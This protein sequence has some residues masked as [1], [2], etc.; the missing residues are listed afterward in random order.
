MHIDFLNVLYK[1]AVTEQHVW[2]M[3]WENSSG[4]SLFS[5]NFHLPFSIIILPLLLTI[6]QLCTVRSYTG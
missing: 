2:D 4:M 1:T 5:C 3:W 6:V